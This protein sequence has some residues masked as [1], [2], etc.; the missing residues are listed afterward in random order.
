MFLAPLSYELRYIGNERVNEVSFG[1]LEGETTRHNWGS[2]L[3]AN[4]TWQIIPSITLQSH[5]VYQTSYKWARVEW[6]NT[7][8]FV[9]NRYFSTKLYLH[10]RYD[11]SSNPTTGTSYFQ[12]KE[13]LSFGINYKW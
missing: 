11:D 9:L 6:E 12:F 5:L 7:F 1:L 2:K 3:D 4:L 13:L 8:N 10:A